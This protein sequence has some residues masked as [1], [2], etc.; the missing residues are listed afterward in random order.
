MKNCP[1]QR[2]KSA[3]KA[4]RYVLASNRAMADFREFRSAEVE[5]TV[6]L[7][8]SCA[9]GCGLSVSRKAG[10]RYHSD[11]HKRAAAT[12]R[13]NE[14]GKTTRLRNDLRCLLLSSSRVWCP[15]DFCRSLGATWAAISPRLRDLRKREFGGWNVQR[16]VLDKHNGSWRWVYWIDPEHPKREVE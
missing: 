16:R 11:K 9:C 1:F 7:L 14:T 2:G 8:P 4:Q 5:G 12:R 10:A 3:S 15:S 13:A 6:P